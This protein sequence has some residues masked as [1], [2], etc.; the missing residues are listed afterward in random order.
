MKVTKLEAET[1]IELLIAS[2]P[3]LHAAGI[4]SVSITGDGIAAT[5]Q[6]PPPALDLRGIEVPAG[7]DRPPPTQHIDPM[8]DPTTYGGRP[9]P[10]FKPPEPE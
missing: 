1:Y 8:Q 3:K 2:A 5:L 10:G 6:P 7:D 9:V 4:T